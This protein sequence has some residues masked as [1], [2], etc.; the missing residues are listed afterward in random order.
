MRARLSPGPWLSAQ[1]Q[2]HLSRWVAYPQV[3]DNVS[4]PLPIR[5]SAVHQPVVS[6]PNRFSRPPP[7]LLVDI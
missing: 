7:S 5:L 2:G 1:T 3:A 4:R 6:T